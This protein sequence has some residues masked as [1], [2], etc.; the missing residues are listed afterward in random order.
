MRCPSRRDSWVLSL[1]ACDIRLVADEAATPVLT[2]LRSLFL[3]FVTSA[4][5]GIQGELTVLLD[6]SSAYDQ[7]FTADLQDLNIMGHPLA[8]HL[9]QVI[10]SRCG[11]LAAEGERVIKIGFLNGVLAYNRGR[12]KAVC[13][14][15][16]ERANKPFWVGS[17]HKLLFIFLCLL[18]ADSGRYFVHSAAIRRGQEGFIFWGASGAG[19]TTVAGFSKRRDVLSDDAPILWREE[20]DFYCSPS[21]FVQLEHHGEEIIHASRV[22]VKR[23]LF[24]HHSP[25]LMLEKKRPSEALHEILSGHIHGYEWMDRDSKTKAFYFFCDYCR[26]IPAFDLHFSK[27]DSFWTL[28]DK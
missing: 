17:L 19:K 13:L 21:P 12:R 22:P 7:R 10:T 8:A 26:Q 5:K 28:V 20:G 23:N 4:S 18:M 25:V 14:L 27:D 24:L 3:G 2:A 6:A 15:F 1:Q 9:D 11:W 16:R